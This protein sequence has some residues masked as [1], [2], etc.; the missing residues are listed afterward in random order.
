LVARGEKHI[1]T[2]L[3][4]KAWGKINLSLDVL[5]LRPDGYH[6]LATVMQS[7]GLADSLTFQLNDSGRIRLDCNYPQLANDDNLVVRGA[8]LLQERFCPEQGVDIYLEKKLPVAAGLGGG[9]SDAAATM[10]AL[11]YLWGLDLSTSALIS[12]G[13]KLGADVPFC[14][15]G[16]TALAQGIGDELTLLKPAPKIWLVLVKPATG[17]SAGEVYK[18]W[19]ALAWDSN[20]YTPG[21]IK[22]LERGDI[23]FLAEAVGNDLERAVVS[24]QPEVEEIRQEMLERGALKAM[25]SGSGPTV[26]GFVASEEQGIRLAKGLW[27]KYPEIHVTYTV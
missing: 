10:K 25:V 19:D 6:Q 5:H 22:A 23:H 16:G 7:I 18:H 26:V 15:V 21:V 12:L 2:G 9:S 3:R 1:L 17:L 27:N 13:S 24:L 11:N 4:L 20:N 8:K 14:L